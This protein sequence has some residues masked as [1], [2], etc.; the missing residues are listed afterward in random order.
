LLFL[1]FAARSNRPERP[2]TFVPDSS[3]RYHD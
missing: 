1:A 2:N 3:V